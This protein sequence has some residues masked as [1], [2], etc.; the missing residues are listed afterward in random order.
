VGWLGGPAAPFPAL[1]PS[2]GPAVPPTPL[3]RA[4]RGWLSRRRH[5]P[6]G[7][8]L[9]ATPPPKP[10]PSF[11]LSSLSPS[12]TFSSPCSSF[13]SP[14]P[15]HRR[16]EPPPRRRPRPSRLAPSLLFP[17]PLP[18]FPPCATVAP[19][20]APAHRSQPPPPPLPGLGSAGHG[21]AMVCPRGPCFGRIAAQLQHSPP[22][23]PLLLL[24][25]ARPRLG[26]PRAPSSAR[27]AR[28]ASPAAQL[29]APPRSTPP[30]AAAAAARRGA[31][32]PAHGARRARLAC[33]GAALSSAS[34]QPVRS[35]PACARPVRG[36]SARPCARACSRGA[37]GASAR[38]V[39]L[40]TRSSTP[41]RAR[42]PPPPYTPC[43]V[44]ALFV[45]ISRIRFRNWL[46]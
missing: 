42:L 37:H 41:G 9:S 14:S 13:P 36:A 32:A 31:S 23:R 18:S 43:V 38:L 45:S 28:A 22:A 24:H 12:R 44:I 40:S 16:S 29:P 21:A 5:P 1:G 3:A 39:M 8:R 25:A 19:V 46:R 33:P 35:A 30:C 26:R 10:R 6:G 27:R 34:A 4:P 20:P 7:A 15:P 11:S 2:G 17:S